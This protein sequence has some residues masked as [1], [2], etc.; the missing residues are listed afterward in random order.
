MRDED[1]SVGEPQVG[2]VV[3]SRD[4]RLRRWEGGEVGR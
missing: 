1:V 4:G 3:L 2:V